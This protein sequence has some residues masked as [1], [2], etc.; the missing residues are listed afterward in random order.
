MGNKTGVLDNIVGQDTA[1]SILINFV[2]APVHAYMFVGPAGTGKR[3][4]A[5]SFA[6]SLLCDQGGCG[7]CAHC[8][9]ALRE[10]H[11]DLVI[12]ERDGPQ[13]SVDTAREVVRLA[14]RSPSVSKRQ[15]I[16]L[17]EFHLAD[18]AASALLKTIEEP[19]P[20]TVFIILVDEIPSHLITIASRCV[21]VP[22]GLIDEK[23]IGEVLIGQGVDEN[24]AR[25]I[26]SFSR[27]KLDRA[28]LLLSDDSFTD[29]MKMWSDIADKLDVAGSTV[30]KTVDAIFA[31]LESLT[32]KVISAHAAELAALDA[33]AKENG[34]RSVSGR[35][36]IEER[37]KREVR[38][39]RTDEIRAGFAELIHSYYEKIDPDFNPQSV[40][41]ATRR[42]EAIEKA[43]L[44][45]N[46]NPN[47]EI[48]LTSLLFELA[49]M[50]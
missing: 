23:V 50:Q 30:A 25:Q 45:L 2:E 17:C 46:R 4:A 37:H 40:S 35:Q 6:A 38:R 32:A 31:T 49:N 22:F 3:S 41:I 12:V 44:A 7:V 47:E 24:L 10:I 48:L 14:Q 18:E 28:S 5:V 26:A 39:I 27:G 11:R 9:D 19:P 43:S 42:I 1:K 13:I 20:G 33:A 34:E 21:Q 8:R 29:R 16:I 36:K 15:V